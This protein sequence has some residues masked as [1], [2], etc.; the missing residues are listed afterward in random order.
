[1]LW[2]LAAVIFQTGIYEY[3][4]RVMLAPAASFSQRAVTGGT[5]S[6]SPV[7]Y[8][9]DNTYYAQ[10]S[11]QGLEIFSSAKNKSLKVIT[12]QENEKIT[13]FTWLPERN[14]A[15]VGISQDDYKGATV[16]LKALNPETN[17][18]PVAPKISGL[19][20]GA[21]I[22][23]VAYSTETNVTN[24]LVKNGSNNAIYRTDANNKLKKVNIYSTRVN[25]IASLRNQDALLYDD[26]EKG[27]VYLAYGS[28][29]VVEISPKGYRYALIGT[30]KGDN[31][32]IGRLND[33]RLVSSIMDGKVSG[34][35]SE[36]KRLDS[37]YPVDSIKIA[38]D[39]RILFN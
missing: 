6:G 18:E 22:V 20:K 8:S 13:Y 34:G 2:L 9:Y 26:V 11:D 32:Y 39:G 29:K 1:M 10:M 12:L 33:Q 23:S 24:I 17:S 31:I 4:D 5:K 16:T 7:Y 15:L 19:S 38:Y 3:M 14:L 36:V 28:G 27:K 25:R 35:F 37:P 30:D 21:K